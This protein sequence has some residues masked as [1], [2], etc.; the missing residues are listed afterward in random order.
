MNVRI[1]LFKPLLF[2]PF[3]ILL[4]ISFIYAQQSSGNKSKAKSAEGVRS[5]THKLIDQPEGGYIVVG[6]A[7]PYK[8]VERKERSAYLQK[9]A[10]DWYL[11]E[12]VDFDSYVE[13][14]KNFTIYFN[15]VDNSLEVIEPDYNYA[16]TQAASDA[17]EKAPQW[18]RN[19]LILIF[20]NISESYQNLWAN[21]ILDAEDPYVDEIA[22]CV[23]HS[24]PQYLMSDYGSPGLFLENAQFIYSNDQYLDYVEVV[25]YGTT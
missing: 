16:L 23:A 3:L 8:P 15:N 10:G 18:L 13:A 12:Q 24:S 5:C 14:D 11:V 7:A 1:T 2:L 19:D 4:S 6:K 20:S 17:L 25:D 21:G 9:T 22:F